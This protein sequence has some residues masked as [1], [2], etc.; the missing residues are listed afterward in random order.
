MYTA[1][2]DDMKGRPVYLR[3]RYRLTSPLDAPAGS[4][5]GEIVF[6]MTENL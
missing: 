1:Q 2:G 3:F 5:V 4:Y 6:T